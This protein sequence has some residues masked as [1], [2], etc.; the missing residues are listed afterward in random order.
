MHSHLGATGES[1]IGHLLFPAAF[2]PD[3]VWCQH[4]PGSLRTS[5]F[6][7]TFLLRFFPVS[8][9]GRAGCYRFSISCPLSLKVQT[10]GHTSSCQQRCSSCD[11]VS[12]PVCSLGTTN[13][14]SFTFHGSEKRQAGASH[15]FWDDVMEETRSSL[16]NTV[17]SYPEPYP[18]TVG[19]AVVLGLSG[20]CSSSWLCLVQQLR[21][22]PSFT[23]L[24][25]T[26]L[27]PRA[28]HRVPAD[29]PAVRRADTAPVLRKPPGEM[30][31]SGGGDARR[32]EGLTK[33]DAP[34]PTL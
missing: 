34:G 21:G 7:V 28:G 8:G 33:S 19:G 20:L 16:T 11:H 22:L 26:G 14:L 32:L 23:P 30:Q 3:A 6:A 31:K 24:T 9:L 15:Y 12:F 1:L 29:P 27:W 13:S 25:Q 4:I 2:S 10:Q 17:G 18:T 5:S